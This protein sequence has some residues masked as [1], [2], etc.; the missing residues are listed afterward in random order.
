MPND[1]K[2][3]KVNSMP[4]WLRHVTWVGLPAFLALW[5]L[6]AIPGMPSPV[7]V[8]VHAVILAHENSSREDAAAHLR[9]LRAI[10]RNMLTLSAQH[11]CN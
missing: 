9:A 6:G 3:Y 1:D 2:T 11:E 7:W 4:D 5:M 8:Q 10:C